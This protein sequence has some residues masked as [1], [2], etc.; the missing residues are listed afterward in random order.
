VISPTT[1][2]VTAIEPTDH[3]INVPINAKINVTFNS[4]LLPGHNFDAIRIYGYH[5][6]LMK[7][8]SGNKLTLH[9]A[10]DVHTNTIYGIVIPAGAVQDTGGKTLATGFESYFSTAG[11][12]L[13]ITSIDPANGATNVP[14][15]KTITLTF[16]SVIR[17]GPGFDYIR[18]FDYFHSLKK[19]ISG[20][21][22]LIQPSGEWLYDAQHWIDI[23]KDAVLSE[24]GNSLATSVHATFWT[25]G[26]VKVS[27]ISPANGA[28]NVPVN[29][30]V[31][32]TFNTAIQQGSGFNDVQ[33]LGYS[34]SLNKT[35]SG[36][37]LMM[38]P[39]GDLA[40]AVMHRV[41]IP[42]GSVTSAEGAPLGGDLGS[43]FSTA[44]SKL[45]VA[46]VDPPDG[47]TNVPVNKT[48]IVTFNTTIRQGPAFGNIS[49]FGYGISISKT[50]DG[51]KLVLKPGT[52]LAYGT[53]YTLQIPSNAVV[54]A[55][56]N[57][58][59]GG[60][61]S[62]F[63]TG[64]V[65]SLQV[66]TFNPYNGATNVPVNTTITVTFSD[67]IKPG[68]R[69]ANITLN[70]PS[71]TFTKTITG[72]TLTIKPTTDLPYERW[73]LLT[74]PADALLSAT[75]NLPM[76]GSRTTTFTTVTS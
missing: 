38:K 15:N 36:S 25:T 60:F 66:T 73:T 49:G 33:I 70:S 20:N 30:T 42:K 21:K 24:S 10:T 11:S 46:A 16:D 61:V 4:N 54:D 32:V 40:Y 53:D 62:S 3:A 12:A 47:A 23:P 75:S 19:T 68:P 31:I 43:W 74:I 27:S 50:I 51:N 34:G 7:T 44:G 37:A 29:K 2:Q 67:N 55:A 17:Q 76:S 59:F 69:Y 41:F 39:S 71:G 58:L 35:I 48:I 72:N 9:P 56:G 8:I 6:A 5:G 22:L 57:A 14:V 18:V 64:G 13:N 52:A 26:N 63:R 28:T 45:S 1:P 65:S